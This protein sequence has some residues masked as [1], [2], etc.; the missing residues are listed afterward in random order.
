MCIVLLKTLASNL[1]FLYVITGP[2]LA[3]V[4][5]KYICLDFC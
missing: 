2:S 4:I 5:S 3:E 1:Y